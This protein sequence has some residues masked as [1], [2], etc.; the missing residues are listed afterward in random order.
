[1][2]KYS[3]LNEILEAPGKHG[4][5]SVVIPFVYLGETEIEN[6]LVTQYLPNL[7]KVFMSALFSN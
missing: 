5:E 1:M 6:A 2:K 3:R 7:L 4:I